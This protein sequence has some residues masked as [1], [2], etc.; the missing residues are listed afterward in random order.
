MRLSRCV[1]DQHLNPVAR[2]Y[3]STG[4]GFRSPMTTP[5]REQTSGL[6]A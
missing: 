1:T 4:E 2:P 6:N 3:P 5:V